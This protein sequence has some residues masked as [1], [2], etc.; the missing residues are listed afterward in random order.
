MPP[1]AW[2][3]FAPSTWASGQKIS[4]PAIWNQ[5]AANDEAAMTHVFQWQFDQVWL[6][7]TAIWTTLASAQLYVP[8]GAKVLRLMWY[9]IQA[10]ARTFQSRAQIAGSVLSDVQSITGIVAMPGTEKTFTFSDVSAYR[11]TRVLI[12]AQGNVNVFDSPGPQ[13]MAGIQ[14][15]A[16]GANPFGL[17]GCRFEY[18]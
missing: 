18:D 9:M 8:P 4:D 3:D 15:S 10:T 11:D 5:L 7:T 6:T 14:T 1:S 13:L 17:I 16:A 12:E 2:T